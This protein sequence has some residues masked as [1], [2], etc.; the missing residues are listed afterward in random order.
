LLFLRKEQDFDL[1]A[2]LGGPAGGC[3]G[4]DEACDLARRLFDKAVK[5]GFESAQIFFD[6]AAVPLV[7]DEPTLAGGRG[8]THSAFETIRRLK[9]DPAMKR[10]HY[11]LRIDTAAAE[12]PGRAVGVC[13]AYA[14]SAMEYGLDA[15]FVN[16]ALHYDNESADPGLLELVNAFV[17]MDGSPEQ[18]RIA[19]EMMAK[20]CAENQKPRK[21]APVPVLSK[22]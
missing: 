20:F 12:L 18:T 4:V 9:T 15:G 14:A 1:V 7:K 10:S 19:K 21:P 17:R 3:P 8:R 2:L 13:R 5:Q 6:A 11:L 22:S 16:P